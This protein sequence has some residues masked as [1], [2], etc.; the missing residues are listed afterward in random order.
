[1]TTAERELAHAEA[2]RFATDALSPAEL[3]VEIERSLWQ[4]FAW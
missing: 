3:A 2:R 1:M 4:Q